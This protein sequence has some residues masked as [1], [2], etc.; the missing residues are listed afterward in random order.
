MRKTP[1]IREELALGQNSLGSLGRAARRRSGE[2][3]AQGQGGGGGPGLDPELA[4]DVPDVVGGGLSADEEGGGDLA[5]GVPGGEQAQDFALAG[6]Q[7]GTDGVRRGASWLGR[8][9]F[10]GVQCHQEELGDRLLKRQRTTRRPG[11]VEGSGPE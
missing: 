9:G 10:G 11:V 4:Q 8:W 6:R 3:A 5:V 1:R 2:T 7:T